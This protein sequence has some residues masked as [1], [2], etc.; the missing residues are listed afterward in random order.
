MPEGKAPVIVKGHGFQNLIALDGF[1]VGSSFPVLGPTWPEVPFV[2]K[3]PVKPGQRVLGYSRPK[4]RAGK[5]RNTGLFRGQIVTALPGFQPLFPHPFPALS[6]VSFV[7]AP[8]GTVA[9]PPLGKEGLATHR[10][11]LGIRWKPFV[12]DGRFQHR[13]K[14]KDALLK[15]AAVRARPP[16]PQHIAGAVQREAQGLPAVIVGAH[17]RNKPPDFLPLITGQLPA[18]YCLGPTWPEVRG[19]TIR[20]RNFFRQRP[21]RPLHSFRWRHPAQRSEPPCPGRGI[22]FIIRSNGLFVKFIPR[23]P[24]LPRVR[25]P[26]RGQPRPHSHNRP[27]PD[28]RLHASDGRP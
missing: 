16:F 15:V 13:V 22:S 12:T 19:S 25:P 10:T 9:L 7:P 6:A 17:L 18:H 24:F 4:N 11:E 28:L 2:T 20:V 14:G 1:Y 23:P 8:L 27:H 5:P 3:Y 26:R 21:F